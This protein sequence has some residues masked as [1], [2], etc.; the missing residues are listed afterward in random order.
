[1][2]E[3]GQLLQVLLEFLTAALLVGVPW[4]TAK[5]LGWIKLDKDAKMR[6][7]V[8]TGLRNALEYA[9]NQLEDKIK[10]GVTVEIKNEVVN[11][12][13]GYAVSHIPDALR[14]FDITPELLKEKLKARLWI[15][16][17]SI[18]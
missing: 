18:I 9:K 2:V 13:V 17:P 11:T 5:L 4:V 7:L 3:I 6:A 12:A 14:H 10:A 15:A 16:P 1:M 8:E